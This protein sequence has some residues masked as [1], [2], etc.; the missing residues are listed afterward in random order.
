MSELSPTIIS[1]V[2]FPPKAYGHEEPFE[3][4]FP[5]NKLSEWHSM[6]VIVYPS[7]PKKMNRRLSDEVL[8]RPRRAGLGRRLMVLFGI[9]R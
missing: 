5:R 1:L 2:S 3:N 8:T 6:N 9:L 7:P 4:K